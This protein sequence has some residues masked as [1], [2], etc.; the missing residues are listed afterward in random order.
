MFIGCH[1]SI[2]KGYSKAAETA[3]SIGANTFQFFTR[4]PRGGKAKAIDPEDVI[5]LEKIRKVNDFGP[6]FAHAAY[7][8]NLASDKEKVRDFARRCL[9]EDLERLKE[10]PQDTIYLFHPG[11]HVGQGTEKGMEWIVDAL[12]EILKEDSPTPICLE[13]MSG[14]GTEIGGSLEDLQAMIERVRYS[15]KMGV[16][17]DACHLYSAGYDVKERL[18]EVLEAIDHTVGLRRLKGIHLNDSLTSLGSKKDR[19]APIGE[20]LIGIDA[21]VRVITHPK[22]KH[23][24]FNLE[25]PLEPEGHQEEIRR[26]LVAIDRAG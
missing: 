16:I 13:G 14:K 6:L 20:G 8:M 7:T 21:L 18:D 12:N 5:K 23:L 9:F 4:N 10:L 2:S 26:L 17:L 24:P 22:L 3:V 1:L 19:H 25:T 11:S 15:E